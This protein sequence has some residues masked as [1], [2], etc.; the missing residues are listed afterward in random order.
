M[1]GETPSLPGCPSVFIRTFGAW[2]TVCWLVMLAPI[3]VQGPDL[4]SA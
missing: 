2:E 1:E 4:R 3:A